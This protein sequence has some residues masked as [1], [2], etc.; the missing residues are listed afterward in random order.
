MRALANRGRDYWKSI[1]LLLIVY[2]IS[3]CCFVFFF[4]Q[5]KAP[6]S[7]HVC[8]QLCNSCQPF[9]YPPPQ[10]RDLPITPCFNQLPVWESQAAPSWE[11]HELLVG[12]LARPQ[13]AVYLIVSLTF[14]CVWVQTCFI[15]GC[16]SSPVQL[17]RL[18]SLAMKIIA[19]WTEQKP[20]PLPP[21]LNISS[22]CETPDKSHSDKRILSNKTNTQVVARGREELLFWP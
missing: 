1:H 21:A 16:L 14:L 4:L 18:T 3:L 2:S 17:Q 10:T 15:Q 20:L 19:R 13:Q 12:H 5:Q 11:H 22:P 6:I 8:L 9:S 7:I